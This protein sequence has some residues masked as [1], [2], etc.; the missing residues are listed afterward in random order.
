MNYRKLWISLSLVIIISFAILGYFGGRIYQVM[1]PIP[2]RVVTDDGRELFTGK[3]IQDGQNVWQSIGGQEV[4]SIW[5]H[6]AYVAPDWNADWLHRE[7]IFILNKWGKAD[8]GKK[9]V[10]LN[11]EQK[12]QLRARLKKEIRTNTYDKKTH[13]LTIS[14]DREDAY[15]YLNSYYSGLF[16]ND[17]DLADIR[18]HYAIP[19]N[20]VKNQARMDDMTT[21]FFWSTW[22]T[23]TNRPDS[24][25]TYTN[26]W[27]NEDLI[28]N[29][30]TG[31]LVIW[32]VVS[33]VMLLAGVGALTWYYAAQRHKEQHIEEVYPEKDPLLALSPTPSMKA[34][35]KYFWVVAALVVV[36][37]GL[38]AVTAHYAVEGSGFYGIPLQKWLPY[39]VARTWHTQLG[40]LWIATAWLATGLF[41]APAVSGHEPKFQRGLVNILFV[42]LLIIVVGSMAGQWFGVFQKFDNQTNFWFGHQGYEY[43]D[44]GRFWQI[45]LTVGLFIWLFLMGRALLP[46]F[47]KSR[48]DRHLLAMFLI[49][50]TAIPLFYVPGL[51]WG[52]HTHLAMAE[53]WRWW[54]VHLWVEG[55][56]EVFATVVIAFLFTRMGLLRTATASASVLFSTSIFLFGGIIGTFHHLYFSG[57]PLGVIAFGAVFSALEVVPLVIIGF[58]AYENLTLSRT[59]PW[60][61]AYK[62]P[63]YC[64]VAVAFWNL[65]GAGLFGFFINPPIALYYMQGLN[66]TAVHGHTALFGVYGMLGIGLMLFCLKG[67]TGQRKWKTKLLSF[68]FWAINIGLALMVLLSLIPIG[69]MQTWASVE[70]GMW[71]ARSAEFLQ[72][73]TVQ[74]FH[75]LRVVGDTIFAIGVLALGWFILG[76]KTGWSVKDESPDFERTVGR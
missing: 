29:R 30:P 15:R 1:P 48:E 43:V 23:A 9:Y 12:A 39:S 67:L 60:V 56:F 68:A 33:F 28:D 75:W 8:F 63:I 42:A 59:K 19:K 51:M 70:Y 74:T 10:D 52:Q 16:M 76:L 5:G 55:F 40:I 64:F 65:V 26:N 38:G 57:T 27:P 25:I 4:G 14:K 7:S 36:Q 47:K 44:L 72:Q 22:S 61:T 53:Y 49:A 71:Y 58:E 24:N 54:V 37:V 73:D 41:M 62:W 66:T 11:E 13:V 17:P 32:S 18:N 3:D 35:L 21:F 6:G 20:T 50:A 2:D 69:L 46:A 34:T 45:F 31:E